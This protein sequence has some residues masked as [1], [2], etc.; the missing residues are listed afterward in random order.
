M[1]DAEDEDEDDSISARC[2][3]P[4]LVLFEP[5]LTVATTALFPACSSDDPA[6]DSVSV[7]CP[8][9]AVV[10]LVVES[11]REH[12]RAIALVQKCGP[13]AATTQ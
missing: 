8:R 2:R 10:I 11:G 13:N 4:Q 6:G 9:Q 12:A 1:H 7:R 5:R 3:V